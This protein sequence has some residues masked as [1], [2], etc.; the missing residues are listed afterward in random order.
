MDVRKVLT[1]AECGRLGDDA[2]A[3]LE[4]AYRSELGRALKDESDK[5][6]ARFEALVKS[7]G[8][9]VDEKVGAAVTEAVGRMKSDAITSKLYEALQKI[10]TI[11]EQAGIPATE[12]TKRLQQE[13]RTA[14][15]NLK[16]A[17]IDREEVKKKL[18]YQSKIN[19][20]YELTAGSSPDV[21]NS[22]IEHFKNSDIREIDKNS[23]ADFIDGNAGGESMLLDVDVDTA[24]PLN[25]D[26]VEAALNE[27]KD[28]NDMDMDGF[29]AIEDEPAKPVRPKLT[30]SADA[31]KRKPQKLE[32]V[33]MPSSGV[34]DMAQLEAQSPDVA[35]AMRQM[36][37]FESLGFGGRFV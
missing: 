24:S 14:D 34:T 28:E 12:V 18:N 11:V 2:I 20:I 29:L 22:V 4:N 23:I 30:E 33:M 26:K 25:M 9:R 3:K 1:E 5:S 7:V 21:I 35:D 16:Q 17:Y 31:R 10:T 13:L 32:R 6:A 15:E 27:I 37:A 19:L 36:A 8:E